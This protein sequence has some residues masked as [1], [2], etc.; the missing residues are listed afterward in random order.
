MYYLFLVLGRKPHKA[1]Q[2]GHK[3]YLEISMGLRGSDISGRIKSMCKG[4]KK[5][6]GNYEKFIMTE[7]QIGRR[8]D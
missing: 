5:C 8:I 7:V 1:L 6:L 2:R 3:F 4:K